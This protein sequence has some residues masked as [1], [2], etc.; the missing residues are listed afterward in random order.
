[1]H[2]SLPMSQP[3]VEAY[4]PGGPQMT[5][6]PPESPEGAAP[7]WKTAVVYQIYV[8][9]FA[10]ADGDGIGDLRG[11]RSR[12]PYLRDLGVDG[13]WICPFFPSPM[14]DFGYDVA[15]T[16]G[17]APSPGLQRGCTP[18]TSTSVRACARTAHAGW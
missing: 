15:P 2:V 17:P 7:W 18:A 16:A 1:M 6:A 8:R 9:S 3:D 12:L 13:V 4:A 10:D 5:C 11:I 14:R